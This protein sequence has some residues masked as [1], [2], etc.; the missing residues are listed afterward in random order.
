MS[1]YYSTLTGKRK[2]LCIG[3]NYTGTSAQL[4]GCHND[5]R[6]LSKFLCERYGYREEDIVMLMDTPDARG[7]SLPTRDNI[8]RSRV[9]SA[10]SYTN[11]HLGLSCYADPRDAVARSGRSAERLALL[12][13]FVPFLASSPRAPLICCP[14]VS[15]HGG[16]QRATEGDEEDGNDETIYPL[17]HK[18]AGIIVDNDM[19]RILVQ[20]LPRGCRLTAIFDCC[21]SGSALDLP[22]MYSTQGK[23]K[24][25]KCVECASSFPLRFVALTW[26]AAA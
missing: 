8:V 19:N 24:E 12:P 13:L 3:I 18:T 20:P 22:Y 1:Q 16:Q 2:A 7:M 15:G 21:H 25:P 14:A 26:L 11:A 23:L 9:F 4:N 17:D 6:N 10:R 5:A